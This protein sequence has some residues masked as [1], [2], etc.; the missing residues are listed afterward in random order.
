MLN[1]TQ[2]NL[3]Q[4]EKQILDSIIGD[5]K[6]YDSRIRPSGNKTQDVGTITGMGKFYPTA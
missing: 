3:R 4:V 6:M 2:S 1:R 5:I